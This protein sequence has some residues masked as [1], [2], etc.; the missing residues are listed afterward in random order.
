M[1]AACRAMSVVEPTFEVLWAMFCWRMRATKWR[2]PCPPPDHAPTQIYFV[3]YWRGWRAGAGS[4][5]LTARQKQTGREQ[6][7]VISDS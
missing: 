5:G 3:C 7:S 4:R 2:E 1:T 6:C